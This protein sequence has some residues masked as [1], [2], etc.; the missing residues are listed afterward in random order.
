MHLVAVRVR[1]TFRTER[2][3]Q[4]VGICRLDALVVA[5]LTFDDLETKLL[6]ELDGAV[7]V[8]LDVAETHG[9]L[10]VR[11]ILHPSQV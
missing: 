9:S 1:R 2:F 5:R 11:L 6:V 7:I 10:L 4:H 3:L 8:D